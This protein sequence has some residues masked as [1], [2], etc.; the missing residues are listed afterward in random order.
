LKA[1]NSKLL[2][3]REDLA[4]A[5]YLLLLA[6]VFGLA[7]HWDLVRVAWQGQLQVRLDQMRTERRA[8]EFKGVKTVTLKE[9]YD[10]WKEGQTLF[11][12][13]RP[14]EEYADLH[15]KGALNVPLENLARIKET[16]ILGM[17]RDRKILVYCS[18]KRCD[19]ALKL[20]QH[21]KSL[22]FT[23]VVA[24]LGGFSAWDEAGYEVDSSR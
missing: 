17:P 3:F 1:G 6:T 18:D 8:V 10:L 15:I 12:D 22:G 4:W 9:A 5:G 21:L 7:Y 16:G 13:A 14:P 19:L 20:A 11:V 23:Q 24:F 2:R